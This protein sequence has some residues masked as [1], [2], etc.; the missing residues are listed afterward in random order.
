V[1]LTARR[2]NPHSLAPSC[3]GVLPCIRLDFVRCSRRLCLCAEDLRRRRNYREYRNTK[4]QK[5]H[6]ELDLRCMVF[7]RNAVSFRWP[8]MSYDMRESYFELGRHQHHI[9]KLQLHPNSLSTCIFHQRPTSA[10]NVPDRHIGLSAFGQTAVLHPQLHQ[11]YRHSY[12]HGSSKDRFAKWLY[13]SDHLRDTI[14]NPQATPR[15]QSLF[16]QKGLMRALPG[17]N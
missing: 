10:F 6:R 9:G 7:L 2:Q 13:S 15:T 12:T 5:T 14:S 1:A 17:Q 3:D 16:V 4:Y 11:N 8:S